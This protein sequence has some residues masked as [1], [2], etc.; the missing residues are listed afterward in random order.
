[1]RPSGLSGNRRDRQARPTQALPN[2]WDSSGLEPPVA[3]NEREAKVEGSRRDDAVGH[4]G[5]E[6]PRDGAQ[7]IRNVEIERSEN[8]RR[9]ALAERARKLLECVQRN[10]PTFHEVNNLHK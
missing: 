2:C 6:L 7:R 4:I 5:H 1:M 3:R 8:E 10:S 9:I